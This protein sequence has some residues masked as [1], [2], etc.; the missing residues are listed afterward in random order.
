MLVSVVAWALTVYLYEPGTAIVPWVEVMAGLFVLG[1]GVVLPIYLLIQNI[2]QSNFFW[3][4]VAFVY[5][6]MA[7]AAFVVFILLVFLRL[8][9]D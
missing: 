5:Q 4:L 7:C 1:L 3:G 8:N 2:K 6:L 9:D